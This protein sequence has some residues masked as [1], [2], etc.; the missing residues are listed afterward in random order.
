MA[1]NQYH[2][3]AVL[4]GAEAKLLA[5]DLQHNDKAGIFALHKASTCALELCRVADNGWHGV[6]I[7]GQRIKDTLEAPSAVT[8]KRSDI[9]RNGGLAC[10]VNE[11][12]LAPRIRLDKHTRHTGFSDTPA[13][14]GRWS[15]QGADDDMRLSIDAWLAP[16]GLEALAAA[17]CHGAI[18]TRCMLRALLS[19]TYRC[20]RICM[21][22]DR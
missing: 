12:E 20:V 21:F 18:Q 9:C 3:V 10:H 7:H 22:V 5:V 16:L 8:I 14:P 19:S 6:A 4:G 13:T 15:E 2:G 1:H 11:P 17:F